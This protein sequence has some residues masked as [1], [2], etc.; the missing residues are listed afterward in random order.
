MMRRAPLALALVFAVIGPAMG[1]D[2]G[3]D[4]PHTV[5]AGTGFTI[6]AAGNGNGVLY[7][8]GPAQAIRRVVQL[9]QPIAIAAGDLN[10]AGHYLV[11]ITGGAVAQT[12]QLDVEPEARPAALSFL[13]KP[14]RL[15][16]GLHNSI[17][18]A[19]YIFDV[20]QNLITDPTSVSFQL[21]VPSAAPQLRS[22]QSREGAAWT[23]LDSATRVGNAQFVAR[24]GPVSSTRVIQEVPGDPCG[25][26]ISARQVGDDLNVETDALRDCSGN[27]VTDG[28]VVTF[29]E[30]WNGRETT[31]DA[32]VKHG[33]AQAQMPAYPGARIS[34]ATGVVMG[35][36]IR[37]EGQK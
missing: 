22:V 18:G 14:S 16:V 23:E 33:V 21:S 11:A 32:P 10:N 4:M 31:V 1:Q 35:N 8:A 25:L 34:A 17:S 9:G 36:E 19:V 20:F 2:N 7:I 15:A 29:S 24:A 27:P 26:K 30:S 28:T 12:G 5:V 37:W 6:R 3:L 13:A